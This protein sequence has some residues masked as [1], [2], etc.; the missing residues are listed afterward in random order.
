MRFYTASAATLLLFSSIL[1][2]QA[3]R[4][5]RGPTAK[6]KKTQSAAPH[7]RAMDDGRA[8]QI[9]TALV[10]AGYLK[11]ASGHWDADSQAAMQ[12]LQADNG[13]QTKLV[14]DSRALIKL[15]L[16]PNSQA[17]PA[18]VPVALSEGGPA[19]TSTE[20]DTFGGK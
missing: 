4:V 10:K 9:Q 14:P 16:G 13:W 6:H 2:L 12:K 15:G 1:P 19:A 8:T 20:V 7:Q 17:A 5:K 18:S 3:S 11:E